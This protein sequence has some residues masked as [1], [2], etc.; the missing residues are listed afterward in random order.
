AKVDE[1]GFIYLMARKKEIIKVGGKRVSPKEIEEV[2]LSMP[3]IVDCTIEGV[4]DEILGEALKATIVLNGSMNEAEM[5]EAIIQKCGEN[6]A[7]Y[8][9]PQ[10]IVFE[11]SMKM[12]ATGKKVKS[13]QV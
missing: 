7:V 8:K 12:S 3:E 6:L 4:E 1:D 2:I 13:K 11:K 5:K 9:I 10:H